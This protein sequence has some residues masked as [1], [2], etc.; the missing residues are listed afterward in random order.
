MSVLY[1]LC[2]VGLK[3]TVNILSEASSGSITEAFVSDVV[4]VIN[5]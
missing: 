3:Y 5:E 2:I 4:S 1:L